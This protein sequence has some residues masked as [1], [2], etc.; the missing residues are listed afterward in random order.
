MTY[1]IPQQLEYKEIIMFGLTFEQLLYAFIFSS[2]SILLFRK[3]DNLII[4]IPLIVVCCSLGIGFVFLNFA[5]L[6]K[7]YWVFL[8]FQK[9]KLG[10]PKLERFI[11]VKD[12][13]DDYIITSK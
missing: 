6:I 2:M 12:I 5:T 1:Q 7:N 9:L 10:D 11:G 3:I 13:Q 8:K 4:A